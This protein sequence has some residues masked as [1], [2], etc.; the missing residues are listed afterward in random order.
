MVLPSLEDSLC[1]GNPWDVIPSGA[2]GSSSLCSVRLFSDLYSLDIS[3]FQH[4]TFLVAISVGFE[5]TEVS[6]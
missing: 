5:S 6:M 2:P 1:R 3:H 4:L